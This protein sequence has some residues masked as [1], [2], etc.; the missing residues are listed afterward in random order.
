MVYYFCCSFGNRGAC[1][2]REQEVL[3]VELISMAP[4]TGPFF[5]LFTMGSRGR[6]YFESLSVP[7]RGKRKAKQRKKRASKKMKVEETSRGLD[8]CQ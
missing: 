1:P 6:V 8:R 5:A 4:A 3:K 7:C 2:L